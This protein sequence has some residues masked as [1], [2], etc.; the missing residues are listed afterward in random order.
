MKLR[1]ILFQLVAL[2]S[3]AA[4]LAFDPFK[5]PDT[6]DSL[7]GQWTCKYSNVRHTI[8]FDASRTFTETC[9]V[10]DKIVDQ[11]EGKW[12][13]KSDEFGHLELVWQFLKSTRIKPGRI[14][15]DAVEILNDK[16]LVL[17]TTGRQRHAYQ[18]IT[19]AAK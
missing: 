7:V 15:R 16:L 9:W 12:Q 10:D 3:A 14:D 5:A 8:T 6:N 19:A 13:L 4:C 11:Y 17:W 18:R 1:S 2:L